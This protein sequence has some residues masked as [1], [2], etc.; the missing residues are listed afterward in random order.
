MWRNWGYIRDRECSKTCIT[1]NG[2]DEDETSHGIV[3]Q[4]HL[5]NTN[6]WITS[7]VSNRYYLIT[8]NFQ[9]FTD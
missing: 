6:S 1:I 8:L 9:S 4:S 7:A 3:K 5:Y 2:Y